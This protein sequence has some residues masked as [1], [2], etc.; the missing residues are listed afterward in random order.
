MGKLFANIGKTEIRNS[1]AVIITIGCFL[2]LYFLIVKPIPVENKDILN[3]AVGFVFGGA[4]AGV[5]GFFFGS[6]KNE[7][8]LKK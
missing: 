3:I 5:V 2:L 7:S 4:L 1:L 8:D 6:S